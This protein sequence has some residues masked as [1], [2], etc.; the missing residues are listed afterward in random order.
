MKAPALG[1]VESARFILYGIP[2]HAV[3]SLLLYS[4]KEAEN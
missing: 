2:N 1:G 4:N 3:I